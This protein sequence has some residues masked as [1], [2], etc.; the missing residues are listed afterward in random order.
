MMKPESGVAMRGYLDRTGGP[1][2]SS[3]L[4]SYSKPER[5]RLWEGAPVI[6]VLENLLMSL[7]AE[8]GPLDL[9]AEEAAG[10]WGI[11]GGISR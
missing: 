9:P 2:M 7:P 8:V 10:W 5:S 3:L 11:R 1:L 4:I 6:S